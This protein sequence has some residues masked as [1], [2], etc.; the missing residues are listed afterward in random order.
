ML[1]QRG[2]GVTARRVEKQAPAKKEKAAP[3][4]GSAAKPQQKSKLTFTQQHLLKTL[5][6]TIEKLEAQ[7]E[8]LQGE[9]N[10]P[11]LFAKNPDKFARIIPAN[12]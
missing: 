12:H 7:L 8:A 1:A 11:N 9:M 2:E 4:N 6:D 10:D 5:P 3:S